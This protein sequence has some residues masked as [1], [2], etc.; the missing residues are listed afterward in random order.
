MLYNGHLKYSPLLAQAMTHGVDNHS[1]TDF[2]E[3]LLEFTFIF[4]PSTSL[5]Q[6][7]IDLPPCN[8]SK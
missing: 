8:L 5:T 4:D 6:A 7:K 2:I 1:T 3:Y